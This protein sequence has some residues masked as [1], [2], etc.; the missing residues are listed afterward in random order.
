MDK[1]QLVEEQKRQRI[2]FVFVNKQGATFKVIEYINTRHVLVEAQDK[3]AFQKWTT[4][5][6][7]SK[8][9]VKNPFHPDVFGVGITGN[10][11]QI[12]ENGKISKEYNTWHH[13][14]RR[15]F[16]GKPLL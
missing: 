3:F 14:L 16:D 7:I 15:C 4:W 12:F 1:K 11:M 5:S 2:G 13:M 8:L 10:Q 6:N 9:N